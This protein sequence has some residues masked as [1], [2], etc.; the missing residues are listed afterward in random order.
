VHLKYQLNEHFTLRASAGKGYRTSNVFAENTSV[1]ASSR[2]FV[3]EEEFKPEVAR[4]Y[5]INF[6]GDLHIAKN[7][8]IEFGLDFYRTDFI[9]QIVA[10]INSNIDE[11]RFY[12]LK[13][14]SYSNSFQV[15]LTAEPINRLEIFSAFR[16]NDV[17]VTMNDELIEKP[18]VSKH[19]A[20]V[21]ISYATEHKKWMID[22]TN[23]F[24]GTS[25]LPDLSQNPVEFRLDENS[26]AY[27]ILHAQITKRFKRIDIYAGAENLSDFKQEN[28]IIDAENPFGDNF[29]AS[30][31]W[32]P[33][34]GRK[35]YAGIRLKIN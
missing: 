6:T 8:E 10:D 34:S 28:L 11:I 31:I 23:Q 15:E 13:G 16:I 12:N 3:I 33:V 27:Y 2:H 19:R 18:L 29:D 7:K 5:G 1:F 32:G 21:T 17:H 9:N 24:I 25:P 30:I 4:N 14:Q 26:P 35:F 22:I 20:L